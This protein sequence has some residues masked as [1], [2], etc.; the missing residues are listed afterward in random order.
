MCRE[1]IYPVAWRG[2]GLVYLKGILAGAPVHVI[3]ADLR[4][5]EV[6]VGVV[7][8]TIAVPVPGVAVAAWMCEAVVVPSK[9]E[10]LTLTC[11][12]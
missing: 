6:K 11:R 8:A 10:K 2:T 9:P 5:P 3:Q 7:V 12:V 1:G 4:D